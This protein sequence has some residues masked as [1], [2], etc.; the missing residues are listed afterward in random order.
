MSDR[1]LALNGVGR[2]C[3]ETIR[4]F[5]VTLLQV[6]HHGAHIVVELRRIF[7]ADAAHLLVHI[8]HANAIERAGVVAA[9]GTVLRQLGGSGQRFDGDLQGFLFAIAQDRKRR[10][11]ARSR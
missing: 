11:L 3:N 4:I 2:K 8:G 1:L 9:A 7:L 10:V 5:F 6:Q